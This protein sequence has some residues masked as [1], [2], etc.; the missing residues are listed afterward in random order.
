MQKSKKSNFF[1][2]NPIFFNLNMNYECFK[3]SIEVSDMSYN[4]FLVILRTFLWGEDSSPPCGSVFSKA[5]VE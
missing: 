3:L 1:D 5:H 2:P 4:Q